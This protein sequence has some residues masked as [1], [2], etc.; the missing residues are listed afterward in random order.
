[1]GSLVMKLELFYVVKQI[2]QLPR[3]EAVIRYA[4][5]PYSSFVAAHDIMQE[6]FAYDDSYIIVSSVE[7][8]Y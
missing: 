7:E 3:G 8:V 6:D 2:K 5:G 1:M 4:R